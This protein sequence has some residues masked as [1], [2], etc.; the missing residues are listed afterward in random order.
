MIFSVI[1][2]NITMSTV[3]ILKNDRN[4]RNSTLIKKH[5]IT[6]EWA[7][8]QKEIDNIEYKKNTFKILQTFSTIKK[9]FDSL[10]KKTV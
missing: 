8:I 10:K 2:N 4:F 3:Y 5:I 6:N 9:T 1:L 7:D